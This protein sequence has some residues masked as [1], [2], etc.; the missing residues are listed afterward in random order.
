MLVH[1]PL[2][3]NHPSRALDRIW[4]SCSNADSGSVG[5]ASVALLSSYKLPADT[6]AGA[7]GPARL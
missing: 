1:G 6:V 2:L 7:A 4:A 5:L 3:E